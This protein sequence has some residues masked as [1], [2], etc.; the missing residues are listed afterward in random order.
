MSTLDAS[1]DPNSISNCNITSISSSSYEMIV[2]G[3]VALVDAIVNSLICQAF[4][5]LLLCAKNKK[6]IEFRHVWEFNGILP[7]RLIKSCWCMAKTLLL[8]LQKKGHKT[9]IIRNSMEFYPS[10]KPNIKSTI[11]WQNP[12]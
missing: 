5:Y 10:Q 8:S 12:Y 4:F 3:C 11:A 9:Y 6:D 7:Q 1:C 2:I